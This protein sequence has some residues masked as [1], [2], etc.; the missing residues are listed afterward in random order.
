MRMILIGGL[1][2]ALQFSVAVAD[3]LTVKSY[4]FE[5]SSGKAV[6]AEMGELRVPENRSIE[7]GRTILLRFVK[8]AGTGKKKGAPIVYLA[9]GPGGSGIDAARGSRFELFMAMR[10]FGDVI[11]LDQRG[12]GM[13]EPD[14]RCSEPYM[15]PLDEPTDRAKAGKTIGDSVRQCFERLSKQGIDLSAY[16]TRESAADLNDLRLALRAPK[17]TLWGI[18]YGTHLALAALKYHGEHIERVILA[19]VEPLHHTLKLPADQEKMLQSIA[20]LAAK[21]ADVHAVLPDLTG[22]IREL[23]EKLA[24]E[25]QSVTL[26]HPLN[27]QSVKVTVGAFDLQYALAEMLVGPDSF[28][29][30][31]DLIARLQQGDWTALALQAAQAKLGKAPNAMSVAMDCASGASEPWLKQIR[32]QAQTTL[33]ADAINFPAPDICSGL[34]DLG[35]EFRSPFDSPVPALLISG[36]LDGRTPPSNAEEVVKHMKNAA[37]L[38][39]EGAGHSD[40][41]FLSSPK[42]LDAMKAFMKGKPPGDLRIEVPVTPMIAPRHVADLPQ[43]TL[44]RYVGTYRINERETRRVVKAGNLLYTLRGNSQPL[45]VRPLSETEFFYEGFSGRLRF[46][47]K[48]DGQVK[49]MTVFQTDSGKGEFAPRIED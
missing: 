20:T 2:A 46:D 39:I 30:M 45:P 14:L 31:A 26:T 43:D 3:N 11:A 4:K 22:A 17:I 24:K 9:G 21:D 5:P 27:G 34:T 19:G 6:V 32:E 36:T 10:E 7:N 48:E 38:L 33:L 18:S 47:L 41:L 13:S 23:I 15:I 49:G 42:I 28:A 8:F 16:N 25:P 44:A 29:S 35:D 40:P 37:H 1:V 12:T